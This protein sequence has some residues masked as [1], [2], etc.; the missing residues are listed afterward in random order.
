MNR[1]RAR[2]VV[3]VPAAAGVAILTRLTCWR[4]ALG[5]TGDVAARIYGWW[6]TTHRTRP[7]F[8]SYAGPVGPS[9]TERRAV[10]KQTTRRY[11]TASKSEK[12]TMLDELCALRGGPA[13]MLAGHS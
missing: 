6:L 3:A 10:T 2:S 11:A 8:D 4:C 5:P 13:G 7:A 12:G 1:P 9:M